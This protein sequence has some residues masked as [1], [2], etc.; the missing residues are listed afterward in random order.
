MLFSWRHLKLSTAAVLS[1]IGEL[2]CMQRARARP[3]AS[4]AIARTGMCSTAP[5]TQRR[6]PLAAAA[7]WRRSCRCCLATAF[8]PSSCERVQL[9]MS[10]FFAPAATRQRGCWCCC[11]V[12]SPPSLCWSLCIL[13]CAIYPNGDFLHGSNGNV[14]CCTNQRG[15]YSSA[16]NADALSRYTMQSAV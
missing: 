5:I 13:S 8:H 14:M 16:Y 12:T 15:T 10:P 7:A 2:K 4:A 9:H 6:S 11:V 1:L 3:M